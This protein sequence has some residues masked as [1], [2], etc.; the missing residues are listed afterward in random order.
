MTDHPKP[1]D[2]EYEV[3]KDV[4]AWSNGIVCIPDRNELLEL[5]YVRQSGK[6]NMFSGQLAKYCMNVGMFA[7]ADWLSRCKTS[8][9]NPFRIWEHARH[10]LEK[11]LGPNHMWIT[12][13]LRSKFDDRADDIEESRML[14]RLMDIRKRRKNRR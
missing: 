8:S 7:A 6:I 14:G 13:E 10:E 12:D 1:G 5:E 3:F 2:P 11:E 4:V 9:T